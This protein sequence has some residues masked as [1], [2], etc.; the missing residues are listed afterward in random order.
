MN[1]SGIDLVLISGKFAFEGS[2]VEGIPYGCGHINDTYALTFKKAEGTTHRY[3]LQRINNS[4]F[5]DPVFLMQNIERV[6]AHLKNKII[7]AGGDYT[8]ET[9]NIIYTK[10][11]KTFYRD[12]KDNYWRAY[13]FIEGAKTYQIVEEDKHFYNAGY[14]VGKFQSLLTDF[15]ASLL[16]ETILKFHDTQKR[17]KDF[18]TALEQDPMKRAEGVSEEIDFVKA[19]ENEMGT[20]VSLLEEG[21]LPVRVTHNDTKFNNVMIDDKTGAGICIIDLDTVMPG[22]YLYDFGDAIRSGTNTAE[23]DEKDLTKVNMD[24]RLFD[25]YA[26]GYL[27]AVKE[28]LTKKEIELL[29]LSAKLMTL[30]CGMRFLTDHLNGDV[31]FKVHREGHNLDRCRTQFKLVADMESK[32][33]QMVQII[34]KYL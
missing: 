34:N 31:Y 26:N 22:S 30:E 28:V 18:L 9:L 15:D 8:R 19:R 17:Y 33:S 7:A 14:A 20:I 11:N 29:P 23:E 10:D 1:N 24:L 5:K 4:I 2:F 3:I 6:T 16:H 27:D 25:I 13:L 12:D 21:A 32:W